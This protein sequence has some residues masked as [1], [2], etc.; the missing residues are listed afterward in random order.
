MSDSRPRP[1]RRLA[2]RFASPYV[3]GLAGHL[4][5]VQES[6]LDLHARLDWIEQELREVPKREERIV[7]RIDEVDA[8]I[9]ALAAGGAADSA[10]QQEMLKAIYERGAEQRGRLYALRES[11]DYEA[12]F[13][14]TAPLV[15]FV[16]PTYNRF[17]LLRERSLPSIL[18]Q[19]YENL[20]VIVSGD[21]S[22]AETARVVE[23]TGDPRVRFINRTVRG[24]Y[25]EEPQKRWLMSGTPPLNDGLA[26]AKGRWIAIL[27]DDDEVTP[28][29][30]EALVAAAQERRLEH[31]YGRMTV[32][33]ADG[34]ELDWE[35][36]FPPAYGHYTLQLAIYHAGL[37]FFGFE[38]GDV[39]YGEPNDWSLARRMVA[40]GVRF[41]KIDTLVATKY[42]DRPTP[43]ID[44]VGG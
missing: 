39:A 42:E 28:E 8:R 2:D 21:D 44:P 19:S 12:A 29:H 6:V 15:S 18:A 31:C 16:I 9:E 33:F 11:A 17:E 34:G 13:T 10:L 1:S 20:E 43:K 3:T 24:P 14:E 35:S 36:K 40:A 25:P 32:R 23:E 37:R 41:G 7:A 30:T 22:P 4:D 38:P 27:G 26:A 5:R